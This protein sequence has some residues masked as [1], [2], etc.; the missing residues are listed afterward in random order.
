M[1]S[2][3]ANPISLDYFGQP[4]EA[5]GTQGGGGERNFVGATNRAGILWGI[6][7]LA[8]GLLLGMIAVIVAI[9]GHRPVSS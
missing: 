3:V 4:L 6:S 1:N 9:Q 7:G 5:G 2:A 8:P